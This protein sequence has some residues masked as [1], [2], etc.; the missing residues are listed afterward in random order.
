MALEFALGDAFEECLDLMLLAAALQLHATVVEIARFLHTCILDADPAP[1]GIV[2]LAAAPIDKCSILKLVLREWG[3]DPDQI[4]SDPEPVS[5][6]SL[7]TQRNDV[8][9][10]FT[11]LAWPAMIAELRTFY[12]RRGMTYQL[13]R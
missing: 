10:D 11:T 4:V 7:Q 8:Y 5:D 3:G 1:T 6:R 12:E 13:T 9:R 2:H